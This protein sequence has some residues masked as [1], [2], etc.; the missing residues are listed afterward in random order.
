M[1]MIL[2]AD[3]HSYREQ[4]RITKP[5][6]GPPYS[7]LS[8]SMTVASS[9]TICSL[10]LHDRFDL[11]SYLSFYYIPKYFPTYVEKLSVYKTEKCG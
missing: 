6:Y 10:D 8:V 11:K 9:I 5:G 4:I 7:F 2:H 3:I 1:H